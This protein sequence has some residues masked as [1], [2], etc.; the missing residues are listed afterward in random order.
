[1]PAETWL[2]TSR[3]AVIAMTGAPRS[4]H[5]WRMCARGSSPRQM[6]TIGFRKPRPISDSAPIMASTVALSR[7]QRGFGGAARAVACDRGS[8]SAAGCVF[9]LLADDI[10]ALDFLLTLEAE[11][12]LF[13]VRV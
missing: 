11:R 12:Q 8:A 2:Q 10:A 13:D 1:M 9:R 4:S 5:S 6:A 7:G 3:N